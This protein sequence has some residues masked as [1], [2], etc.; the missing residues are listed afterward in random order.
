MNASLDLQY[1]LEQ[2]RAIARQ[3]GELLMEGHRKGFSIQHK[4]DEVDLVTEYDRRSEELVVTF[5]EQRFPHCRVV[6]EEGTD[7]GGEGRAAGVWYVDPLD[8]TTNYAHGLPNYAVSIG[9][10]IQERP[11]AGVVYAPELGWEFHAVAGG[12]AFLGEQPLRVSTVPDLNRSLVGT[13][14][15]YD[16]R[17]SSHDNLPQLKAVIKRCQGIRRMG[18][19][20]MDCAMVAQGHLDA[21]WEF[22]LNSWD[23]CAGSLLITEAGG[24]VSRVDGGP[25]DSCGGQILASNGLVHEELVAALSNTLSL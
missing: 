13:G 16:R 4:R 21:Y 23:I 14:F 25:F 2:A 1:A 7:V 3:A 24:R 20:S 18:V 15:P 11:V 17:T 22:K 8:G 19:A 10:E 9:L 12:G 5:L 6:G